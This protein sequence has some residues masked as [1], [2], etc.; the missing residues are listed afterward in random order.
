MQYRQKYNPNLIGGDDDQ[1][2]ES[3]LR[4][5]H[6]AA[7]RFSQMA[8]MSM[9]ASPAAAVSASLQIPGNADGVLV[10]PD[11]L[12]RSASRKSVNKLEIIQKA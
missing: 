9:G 11:Q 2:I 5:R 4:S 6:L 7:R 10:V 1:E 12:E 3:H 8:L